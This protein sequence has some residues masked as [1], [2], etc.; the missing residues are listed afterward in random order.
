MSVGVRG[1]KQPAPS[2][3][4]RVPRA[5]EPQPRAYLELPREAAAGK[6]V[7]DEEIRRAQIASGVGEVRLVGDVERLEEQVDR[8]TTVRPQ[9]ITGAQ[10]DLQRSRPIGAVS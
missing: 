5:S 1:W 7:D 8:P 10:I 4:S 3:Q 9:P 2:P 6:R